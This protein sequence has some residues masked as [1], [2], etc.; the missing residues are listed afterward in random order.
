MGNI[1]W[2]ASY[3]KSG[4]TWIRAFLLNLITEAEEPVDINKMAALTYGDSQIQWY[5]DIPN[6]EEITYESTKLAEL[7]PFA[8]R[9]I[10]EQTNN[11]VF[12]KTHNALVNVAGV[13]MITRSLT[14]GV[15]YVVRN[16]L[17]VLVS[18]ADHLGESLDNIIALMG[19]KGFETPLSQS[20][21]PEHHSDWST[22]VESWT[23]TPHAVL[24]I[25]RFED[26]LTRPIPTFGGIAKFL[27]VNVGLKQ[28]K[29]AIEFASF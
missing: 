23:N 22:H 28:L 5:K 27:G 7:R 12:V 20:H 1:V 3:P 14:A 11:S 15:I 8:H 29:Q 26:M 10:A 9:R 21:V 24:H 17:D 18:Y 19:T 6:K 13:P 2:L 4:N 25:V 16:P